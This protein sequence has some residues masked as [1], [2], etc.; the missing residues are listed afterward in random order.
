[1]RTVVS[2]GVCDFIN[3]FCIFFKKI[4]IVKNRVK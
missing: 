3:S 4:E 1:M 2:V